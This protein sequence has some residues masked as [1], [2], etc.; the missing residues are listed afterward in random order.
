MSTALFMTLW[1]HDLLGSR[2]RETTVGRCQADTAVAKL[3]TTK[4]LSEV[5]EGRS[6]LDR[7]LKT[8]I[9]DPSP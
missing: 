3:S 9:Y 8:L 5:E 2:D 1:L 7:L 6:L 4:D